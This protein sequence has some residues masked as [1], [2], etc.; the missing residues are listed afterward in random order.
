M[1]DKKRAQKV[2]HVENK[3][4]E[5]PT[6][7]FNSAISGRLGDERLVNRIIDGRNVKPCGRE[8]REY[9]LI[10]AQNLNHGSFQNFNELMNDEEFILEIA[11]ITPNPTECENYFYQYVNPYLQ[12]KSDFRLAFLKQIYLNANVYKLKDINLIVEWC[13]FEKENQIILKDLGFKKLIEKRIEEINYQDMIE[14]NCSGADEKELRQYKVKANEFKV[15]CEN[16]VKGLQ[17]IYS[18][19]AGEK[20][21]FNEFQDFWD[22]FISEL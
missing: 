19:F 7:R 1:A 12:K 8:C 22:K 5:N 15:L 2:N 20:K 4:I 13:G 9:G 11:L 14:Y 21:E 18:T 16:M 10:I 17:E 3:R 6:R